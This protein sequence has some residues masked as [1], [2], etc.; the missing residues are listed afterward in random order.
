M[1]DECYWFIVQRMEFNDHDEVSASVK[2]WWLFIVGNKLNWMAKSTNSLTHSD[3][4]W[5]SPLM[6]LPIVAMFVM[7]LRS[8]MDQLRFHLGLKLRFSV[9]NAT[10][11]LKWIAFFTFECKKVNDSDRLFMRDG[12]CVYYKHLVG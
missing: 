2:S 3:H 8:A 9:R 1:R 5:M 10:A 11:A 4:I 7:I 6:F 12:C